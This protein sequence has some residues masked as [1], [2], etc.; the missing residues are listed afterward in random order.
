MRARLLALILAL[1]APVVVTPS[2]SAAGCGFMG[3][4][5]C[6]QPP[7]TN[8]AARTPGAAVPQATQMNRAIYGTPNK[9]RGTVKPTKVFGVPDAGTVPVLGDVG[10]KADDGSYVM[11]ETRVDERTVDLMVWSA[12]LLGP[13][14]VRIQ[15][16][17]SW[18]KDPARKYPGLWLLHGG[19]DPADYQ[20]WTVYSQLQKRTSELEAL[21]IM[22][23]SGVGG[24]TTNYLTFGYKAGKQYQ[25]FVS[26][27]LMQ[28]LQRGYKLGEKN[29]VAGASAGARSALEVAFKNPT[30]FGAAAA[31]SG[32]LDTQILGID[33][34]ITTGPLAALQ[35]PYEMWGSE[36]LNITTWN[37]RNP[38][39][40]IDKLKGIKTYVSVGDGAQ[41]PLDLNFIV[42]PIEA[43]ANAS[44]KSFVSYAQRGG[45]DI[46]ADLYGHGV[47]Q[48]QYF[49]AAFGRSLPLLLGPLGLTMQQPQPDPIRTA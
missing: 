21:V 42:D 28:I 19:G 15:L 5:P 41:G 20:C 39:K 35:T 11:Y 6:A 30:K 23:S 31:Y 47:H 7:V 48:W 14:P 2:A 33:M 4:Q 1:A 45:L 24:H 10:A 32:L 29:A 8:P 40:N 27:E 17:P 43:V 49:D 16:P 34:S 22:P 38:A 18:G 9:I 3:F 25:T 36:Y 46:T 44:T 37:D 26:T 12:G 13:A